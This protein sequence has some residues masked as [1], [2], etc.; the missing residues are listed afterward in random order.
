MSALPAGAD[1]VVIASDT[2]RPSDARPW[3]DDRR[4]L[5]V[6]VRRVRLLAADEVRDIAL[7]G[8][9][10]A[11]GWHAVER[12]AGGLAV[13][14]AGRRGWGRCGWRLPSRAG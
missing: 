2:M 3:P 9:Q 10:L 5:G 6:Q 7:D 11:A 12:A 4:R 8:P 1:E 13:W 14:R